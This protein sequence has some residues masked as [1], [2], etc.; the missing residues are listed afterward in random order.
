MSY[1]RN[2][3]LKLVGYQVKLLNIDTENA[4]KTIQQVTYC[5]TM[6]FVECSVITVALL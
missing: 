3:S 6:T 2:G 1:I 4:V 5:E